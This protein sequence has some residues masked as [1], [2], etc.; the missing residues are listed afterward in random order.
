MRGVYKSTMQV[1]ESKRKELREKIKK[2]GVKKYCT[3]VGENPTTMTK[4]MN[5]KIKLSIP[6]YFYF[7]KLLEELYEM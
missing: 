6:Q 7:K 3:L 2:F 1:S 4:R 5:G